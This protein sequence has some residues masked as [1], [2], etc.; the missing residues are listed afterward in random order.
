MTR[1]VQW[2]IIGLAVLTCFG[3]SNGLAYA[4]NTSKGDSATHQVESGTKPTGQGI[5]QMAKGLGH[6]V[7]EGAKRTGEKIQEA[8]KEAQPQVKNAWEKVK[9]G[10]ESAG[11]G[12]KNVFQKLFGH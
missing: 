6:T 2:M 3:L 12:V 5:E 4:A 11:V 8:G 10:A 1:V 9:D 7:A